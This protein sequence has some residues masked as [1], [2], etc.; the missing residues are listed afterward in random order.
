MNISTDAEKAPSLQHKLLRFVGHQSWIPRGR[1]RLVHMMAPL[2]KQPPIPF[3]VPFFSH[4]WEGRLDQFLDWHVYF[5]GPYTPAE[6]TFLRD[7]CR[8][9]RAQRGQV[10]YFDA[11]ANTGHHALFVSGLVD[12]IFAFEPNPVAADLFRKRM[13]LNKIQHAELFEVAL[14]ANEATLDLWLPNERN[15]GTATLA[16][17]TE[18]D[19][20]T[21]RVP[22]KTLDSL[23]GLPRIDILKMDVQ[24]WES[25][26]I[27]GARRK[28]LSDRPIILTELSRDDASGFGTLDGLKMALYPDH[29]LYRINA[30]GNAYYLNPLLD[31]AATEIVC[32]PNEIPFP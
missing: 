3:A 27:A 15:L 9:I 18:R 2:N 28:L 20:V 29:A 23:P 11:G 16:K 32:I 26:V 21:A 6:L 1:H 8:A 24:G 13:G 17:E 19:T 31:I 5:F 4:S 12:H 25:A 14:G 10:N 30:R 22:V 7:A